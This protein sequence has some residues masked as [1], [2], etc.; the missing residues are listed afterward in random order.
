MKKITV[1]ILFCFISLLGC[2]QNPTE[3]ANSST[4]PPA[5]ANVHSDPVF[6]V[7]AG[8]VP[9]YRI[10]DGKPEQ[11]G[12]ARYLRARIVVPAGLSPA[13]LESNIR[14]AAKTLY[15]R[16]HPT[17]MFVFANKE[18]TDLT[19]MYTAGRCDFH[20]ISKDKHDSTLTIEDYEAKIDLADNYFRVSVPEPKSTGDAKLDHVLGIDKTAW[21]NVHKKIG[22]AQRKHIYYEIGIA[23]D[24]ATTKAE[25]RYPDNLDAAPEAMSD[26][27][28]KR[29][30][31][32]E[33][34]TK[35]YETA[36]AKKRHLSYAEIRA[37]RSEGMSATWPLP[38]GK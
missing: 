15:E 12:D 16:Y 10:I 34:L 11:E 4:S 18:G 14:H 30:Q 19:G 8:T 21:R 20:P 22:E 29:N 27:I 32:E 24:R 35:I 38:L 23:D 9:L 2:S 7:P 5:E 17:G 26:Q 37:I 25:K 1:A 13:T 36:L 3:T 6:A 31:L 28:G 33:D